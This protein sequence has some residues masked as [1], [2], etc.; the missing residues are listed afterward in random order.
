MRVR[1]G[2]TA[3]IADSPHGKFTT[4][5]SGIAAVYLSEFVTASPRWVH[6]DVYAS[7][8]MSRPGRPEGGEATGLRAL[9]KFIRT[10]YG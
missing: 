9:Y 2:S 10:R 6:L 1:R 5:S 3:S 7:N 4:Q 8:T